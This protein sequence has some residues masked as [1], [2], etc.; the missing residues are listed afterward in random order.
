MDVVML[1]NN[2][3]NPNARYVTWAY[4]PCSVRLTNTSGATAPVQVTLRNKPPASGGRVVF[5]ATGT[6]TRASSL[7]LT[8]P[9]NGG[10]IPFFISGDFGHPST[11]DGDC[12]IQVLRGTQV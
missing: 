6:S 5:Q 9:L 4:S 11:A 10:S 1:I 2:S 8:L 12:V 3:A 7:A